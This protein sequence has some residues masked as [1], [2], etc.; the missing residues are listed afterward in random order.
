MQEVH[1]SPHE[2]NYKS[3]DFS[4][5]GIMYLVAYVSISITF[6]RVDTVTKCAIISHGYKET[7]THALY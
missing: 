6:K 7:H 3:T 2:L 5:V 4:Q 1:L